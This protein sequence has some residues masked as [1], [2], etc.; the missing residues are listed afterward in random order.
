MNED[1]DD[2]PET[3]KVTSDVSEELDTKIKSKSSKAASR[4][5]VSDFLRENPSYCEVKLDS[6][7]LY[8]CIDVSNTRPIVEFLNPAETK[9][10]KGSS[11]YSE[12]ASDQL[13]I[14]YIT[15]NDSTTNK[16]LH[17]E[18]LERLLLLT[19]SGLGIKTPSRQP[20]AL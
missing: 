14:G 17:V 12:W 20:Y 6:T 1:G 5:E 7:E 16:F 11:S 13:M 3:D 15:D 8:E 19:R 18:R 10:V 4:E 2:S 9:P